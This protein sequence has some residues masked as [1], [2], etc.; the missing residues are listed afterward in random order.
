MLCLLALAEEDRRPV[1]GFA[2]PIV[3]YY[4]DFG[5]GFGALG[6]V[7]VRAPEGDSRPW[8]ARGG[9]QV[10]TTSRGYRNHW[11]K[12]DFPE[13]GGTQLRW[14]FDARWFALGN[15][16]YFGEGALPIDTDRPYEDHGFEVR[17]PFV[18]SNLRRPITGSLDALLTVGVRHST[19]LYAPGGLVDEL[20]PSG[21]TPSWFNQVGVGVLLDRRDNEVDPKRGVYDELSVRV[22]HP[23]LASDHSMVALHVTD[24]HWW[25]LGKWFSWAHRATAELRWGDV[26]FYLDSF[27]G[28]TRPVQLGGAWAWR[29]YEANR[30]RGN[31]ILL[32][33]PELFFRFPTITVRKD[34]MDWMLVGFADVGQVRVWGDTDNPLLVSGG[35]GVRT[36]WH[37]AFVLRA[38][39]AVAHEQYADGST[40]WVRGVYFLADHPFY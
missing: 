26:P 27:T 8:V 9:A 31:I 24:R 15:A 3:N 37:D 39:I 17:G 35:M 10:Y 33:Q 34:I 21:R 5:V 25:P 40:E 29:G 6:F 38:D 28:G 11:F 1:E 18:Y 30:F 36:N 23:V 19:P 14:D 12:M 16:Y 2:L 7:M 4:S 13:I 20:Q 32:A 22:A